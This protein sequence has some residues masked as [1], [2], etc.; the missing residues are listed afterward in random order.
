MQVMANKESMTITVLSK[1]SDETEKVAQ[2]I[3]RNLRGGEVIE[4]VS[5]LGGG[6]TT[7]VRGLALGTGS[8]DNVTSPSYTIN[9]IYKAANKALW[10]FD[11]YRLTDA[12]I[13]AHELKE[14]LAN[15]K[16]VIVVEWADVVHDVLP[17]NRLTVEL[18]TTGELSRQLEIR[19]PKHLSYLLKALNNAYINYPYR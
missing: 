7:F 17:K 5:D 14:A 11:F 13:V 18:K 4:L 19:G 8:T 12:G 6:K 1:S 16:N 2:T 10:H 15:Q 3:G 9:N